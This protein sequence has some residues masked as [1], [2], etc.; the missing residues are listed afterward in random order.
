MG[1]DN[2]KAP[3]ATSVLNF[4]PSL[5]LWYKDGSVVLV[6]EKTAFR[7]HTTILAANCE[8]FR[9]MANIPQ[10]SDGDGS[11]MYEKCPVIRLGDTA[12]DMK[13]FLQALYDFS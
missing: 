2:E 7:V 1:L 11:E 8:V 6:T 5:D 4:T 10:P 3:Y 12:T 13:H 9:D